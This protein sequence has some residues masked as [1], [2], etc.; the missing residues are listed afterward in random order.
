MVYGGESVNGMCSVV[1]NQN[2]WIC[3]HCTWYKSSRVLASTETHTAPDVPVHC[4][5]SKECPAE[6]R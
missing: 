3:V 5:F 2:Y 1:E 6:D 4:V